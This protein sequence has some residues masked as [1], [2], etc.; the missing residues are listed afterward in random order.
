MSSRGERFRP[1]SARSQKGSPAGRIPW[2]TLVPNDSPTPS[3]ALIVPPY[4]YHSPGLVPVMTRLP[5]GTGMAIRNEATSQPAAGTSAPLT[6]RMARAASRQVASSTMQQA[7]ATT[8]T[9]PTTW[10]YWKLP[11]RP[12]KPPSR[13]S[14]M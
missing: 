2:R 13:N 6:E 12:S 7:S 1:G 14:T 9:E 8:G 3:S 5:L 4:R 11:I 10:L